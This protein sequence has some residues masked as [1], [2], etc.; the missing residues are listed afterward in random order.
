MKMEEHEMEAAFE[1]RCNLRDGERWYTGVI[2][3]KFDGEIEVM[4]EEI[5]VPARSIAEAIDRVLQMIDHFYE[6]QGEPVI[7]TI[8]ERWKV[9]GVQGWSS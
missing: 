9:T 5:D 2:D 3:L 4:G 7:R 6:F 1:G 8:D